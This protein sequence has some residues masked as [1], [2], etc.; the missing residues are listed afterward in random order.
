MTM[1][2]IWVEAIGTLAGTILLAIVGAFVN[3]GRQKPSSVP[4]RVL[5]IPLVNTVIAFVAFLLPFVPA[6]ATLFFP[7]APLFVTIVF[8]VLSL[9]GLWMV[10]SGWRFRMEVSSDGILVQSLLRRR[11]WISWVDVTSVRWGIF[12]Q[13]F[14]LKTKGRRTIVVESTLRGL[15]VFARCLLEGV[16]GDCIAPKARELLSNTSQGL[17]PELHY[18]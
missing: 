2:D 1:D 6:V 10:L 15:P 8:G 3:R 13:A 7:D 18:G 9:P 12:R 5:E 16:S 17:L 11:I 4:E 14:V